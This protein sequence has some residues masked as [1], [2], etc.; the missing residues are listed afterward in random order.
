MRNSH[1]GSYSIPDDAALDLAIFRMCTGFEAYS[2]AGG[3]KLLVTQSCSGSAGAKSVGEAP[4]TYQRRG[5]IAATA[6]ADVTT[7]IT[8]KS[9]RSLHF[10]IHSSSGRLSADSMI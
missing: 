9:I 5:A 1:T 2:G 6:S 4:V 8:S 10:P 3:G 7:G